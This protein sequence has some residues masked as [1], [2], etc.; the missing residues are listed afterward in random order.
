MEV[1]FAMLADSAQASE[2]K[3]YLLGGGIDKIFAKAFPAAHPHM[4]LILKL[5]LDSSECERE[6]ALEIELWDA[7]GNPVG[8]KLSAK[9][10]AARED[11]GRPSY[12]LLVLNIVGQTF[13]A[14]G[15]YAFKVLVNGQLLKTLPLYLIERTDGQPSD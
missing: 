7:D 6:H 9:F 12:A 11:L 5:K 15:D 14:A 8:A 13:K 4:A 10:E 3:V 2:G 1:E